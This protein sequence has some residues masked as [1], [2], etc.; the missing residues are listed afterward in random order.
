MRLSLLPLAAGLA[1]MA[2]PAVAQV[3]PAPVTLSGPPLLSI[4]V[5]ESVEATPDLATIST[6]VEAKGATASEAM[7][8]QAAAMARLIAAIKAAGIEARDIQ[9][10]AINLNAQYVYG[11]KAPDGSEAPPRFTGYQASNMLTVRSRDISKLGPLLDRF[12]AAGATNINGPSFSID[13]PAP[14]A[15]QARLKAMATGRA[16]AELYAR[17]A[18]YGRVRLV[19]VSEGAAD[20]PRP[21]MPMMVMAQRLEKADTQ[22]EPGEMSTSISVNLTYAMEN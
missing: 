7:A 13:K 5:T 15:D 11:Q 19:S 9:T 8:R 12:V 6:G 17:A 22:V 20:Y 4:S 16:R 1:L 2:I 14:L 21:P 18:G 10:S 3:G